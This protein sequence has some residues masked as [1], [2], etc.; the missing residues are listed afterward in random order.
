MRHKFFHAASPAVTRKAAMPKAAMPKAAS[1]MIAAVTGLFDFCGRIVC[2]T[3]RRAAESRG[4]RGSPANSANANEIGVLPIRGDIYM[5]VGA[6]EHH[7][8][9][10]AGWHPA[11]GRRSRKHGAQSSGG[12]QSL[13]RGSGNQRA[14]ECEHG[15]REAYPHH[16]QHACASRSH[17]WQRVSWRSPAARSP[18]AT[19]PAISPTSEIRLRFTR[20]KKC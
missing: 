3:P 12:A 18:E 8:V 16:H 17:G 11:G 19:W 10:G 20:M 2:S 1:A 6:E 5:L 4:G 15:T 14:A 7:G 13:E 9:G